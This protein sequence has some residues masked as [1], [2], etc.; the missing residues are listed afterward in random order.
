MHARKIARIN[1]KL[2]FPSIFRLRRIADENLVNSRYNYG[3]VAQKKRSYVK[4]G[5]KKPN[6]E[7]P[8]QLGINRHSKLN[9]GNK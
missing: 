1:K 7:H 8:V 2:S 5:K 3:A 9:D 4:K 6:A